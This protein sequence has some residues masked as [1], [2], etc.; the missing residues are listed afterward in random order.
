MPSQSGAHCILCPGPSDRIRPSCPFPRESHRLFSLPR[1]RPW[2]VPVLHGC[3]VD[4]SRYYY[5]P[6]YLACAKLGC[7]LLPGKAH[8]VTLRAS[9]LCSKHTSICTPNTHI[10]S[11]LLWSWKSPIYCVFKCIFHPL[12]RTPSNRS[13]ILLALQGHMFLTAIY[14]SVCWNHMGTFHWQNVPELGCFLFLYGQGS[15][16]TH[17]GDSVQCLIAYPLTRHCGV[18]FTQEAQRSA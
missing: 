10:L 11:G 6:I 2:A 5:F 3:G 12:L 7:H 8:M 14:S 17:F 18:G 9:S 1:Q 4:L 15:L 13:H 16:L